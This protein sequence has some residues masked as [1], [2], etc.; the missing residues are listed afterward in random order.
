VYRH[1]NQEGAFIIYNNGDPVMFN[2]AAYAIL[3]MF[4]ALEGRG[5]LTE[6]SRVETYLAM[7]RRPI[8]VVSKVQLDFCREGTRVVGGKPHEL[9]ITPNGEYIS[10]TGDA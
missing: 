8:E 2:T 6:P 10:A 9:A 3:G 5:M 4:R 1:L 7:A